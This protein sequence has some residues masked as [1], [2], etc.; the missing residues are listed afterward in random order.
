MI[1]TGFYDVVLRNEAERWEESREEQAEF[2]AR[3]ARALEAK[4]VELP[5]SLQQF[6]NSKNLPAQQPPRKDQ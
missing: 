1:K 6:R 2:G 3:V 4:G 5:P